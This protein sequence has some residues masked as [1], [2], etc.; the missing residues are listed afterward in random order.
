ME[1]RPQQHSFIR[2]SPS[3][4]AITTSES[5]NFPILPALA[6]SHIWTLLGKWGVSGSNNLEPWPESGH[7]MRHYTTFRPTT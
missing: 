2:M 4:H 3:T 5:R 6:A 7:E 1:V